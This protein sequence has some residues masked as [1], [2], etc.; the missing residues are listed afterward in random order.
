MLTRRSRCCFS[1]IGIFAIAGDSMAGLPRKQLRPGR[2]RFRRR[3]VVAPRR[4]GRPDG[5]GRRWRVR[6][7]LSWSVSSGQSGPNGWLLS[8]RA[9]AGSS[10]CWLRDQVSSHRPRP[11]PLPKT[12]SGRRLPSATIRTFHRRAASSTGLPSVRTLR[13]GACGCSASARTGRVGR[14]RSRGVCRPAR[15]R[16][17]QPCA[18]RLVLA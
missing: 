14:R 5:K 16:P 9:G 17:L 11:L 2:D 8:C 18:R 1:P 6:H 3:G 7:H 15:P 10:T 12:S 4:R 13:L